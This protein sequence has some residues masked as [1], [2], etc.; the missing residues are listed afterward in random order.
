[1]GLFDKFSEVTGS[2]AIQDAVTSATDSA[3]KAASGLMG[4][5]KSALSSSLGEFLPTAKPDVKTPPGVNLGYYKVL[6]Q[7]NLPH[8]KFIHLVADGPTDF[9]YSTSLSYDSPYQDMGEKVADKVAGMLGPAGELAKGMLHGAGT[10]LFTQALTAKVWSG[11]GETTI[12]VP[13]IFQAETDAEDDVLTPLMQLMY[14]SMPREDTEGGFLS[15]PGPVFD[16]ANTVDTP[17][18]AK[19]AYSSSPSTGAPSGDFVGTLVNTTV[20]PLKAILSGAK[21]ALTGDPRKGVDTAVTGLQKT[22]TDLSASLKK[23]VKYPISLQIGQGF[24]LENVVIEAV[25]QTHRLQPVGTDYNKSSGINSRVTVEVTFKTFYTL[26]QR[27]I[28]RMLLPMQ[29]SGGAKTMS[30]YNNLQSKDAA[31]VP[32]SINRRDI[33]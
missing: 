24:R 9:T 23:M 5:A 7:A 19:D 14:L 29:G 33:N 21:Q 3:S 27:D 11:A 16:W 17:N 8:G 15:G 20:E 10:R 6:I 4:T 18:K 22:L 26:T 13:L 28:A 25:S 30:A 1:M 12:Q 31:Y 2:T 32:G